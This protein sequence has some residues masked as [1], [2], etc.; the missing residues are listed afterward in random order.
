MDA[1]ADAY[2]GVNVYFLA[3]ARGRLRPRY[4]GGSE[5]IH[6]VAFVDLATHSPR[7]L[8]PVDRGILRVW[9]RT[10]LRRNF[11]VMSDSKAAGYI[12]CWG[13]QSK[14]KRSPM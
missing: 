2:R 3:H 5:P 4:R 8:Y 6:K 9:Q 10:P 13:C 7:M 1:P 12:A 11:Y 14:G